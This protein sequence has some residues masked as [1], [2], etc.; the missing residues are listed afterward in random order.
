LRKERYIGSKYQEEAQKKY[1][2]PPP[3]TGKEEVH[4]ENPTQ[5]STQPVLTHLLGARAGAIKR[6]VNIALNSFLLSAC[7][8]LFYDTIVKSQG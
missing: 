8:F 3:G 1:A 2:K 4:M 6:K 5:T 7:L